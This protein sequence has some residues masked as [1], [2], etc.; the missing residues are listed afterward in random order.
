MDR[1]LFGKQGTPSRSLKSLALVVAA[2]LF[3]FSAK[4]E[5]RFRLY[6]R[7][8][9][10]VFYR[11]EDAAYCRNVAEIIIRAREEIAFDFGCFDS[12]TVSVYLAPSKKAFLDMAAGS[13]PEWAGA[14]AVP[15]NEA[16][17]IKSPRWHNDDAFEQTIVHELTHL[18]L[19]SC[20]RGASAPR[21]LDEGLAVFYSKDKRWNTASTLSKALAS[22]S[23]IPLEQIDAVLEYRRSKADL[24]YHQSYSAVLYLLQTY[25]VDAL[26]RL[27]DGLR[28]RRPLDECFLEAVGS[29]YAGFEA[30]WRSYIAA[31]E[32]WVW[33]YEID[34][35]L[36][37][38]I[39]LLACTA[40][41]LR[42]IR[43]RRIRR[44]WEAAE[45]L[46]AAPPEEPMGESFV[47][48]DEPND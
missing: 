18:M 4:A 6:S 46:S 11:P 7:D 24:A 35:Y 21:W 28:R 9:V 14:F 10:L 19:H 27:L 22:H 20:L 38:L 1:R 36:W 41:V 17:V 29:T 5:E 32:K 3:L 26:R 43:N 31:H 34:D 47:V 39:F 37:L 33:F 48:K 2:F 16:M 44:E 12:E 25:D 15:G 13:L 30:E 8:R 42:I 40:F 45:A 23:L